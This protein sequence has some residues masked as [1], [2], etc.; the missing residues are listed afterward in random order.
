MPYNTLTESYG[1]S[2]AEPMSVNGIYT[3][4][5]LPIDTHGYNALTRNVP[6]NTGYFTVDNAYDKECKRFG[7]RKCD[8]TI[9]VPISNMFT[10]DKNT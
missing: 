10:P 2:Y 7:L 5:R 8:G 4:A 3:I 6:Y 1:F 9:V